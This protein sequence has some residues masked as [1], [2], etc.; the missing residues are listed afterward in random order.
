MSIFD[1]LT[2]PSQYTGSH[3]NRFD[4]SGKGKGIEGRADRPGTDGY[5]E[6]FKR[7]PE[8][9]NLSKKDS[10]VVSRLTNPK[11]FTGT[12]KERFDAEGKGKGIDGRVDRHENSG[13][14]QG[15]AIKDSSVP[16]STPSSATKAKVVSSDSEGD[17]SLKSEA[18]PAKK[19]ATPTKK[20]AAP[21]KSP[22]AAGTTKTLAKSPSNSSTTS[23]GA[24][25]PSIF[26]KLTDPS[27]YT[28]S[29]KNRF[30]SEGKGR[31]LAGR[32][33]ANVSSDGYVSGFKP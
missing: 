13:Y 9:K 23:T 24:K 27:Q 28:G 14:V 10:D 15:S 1:K 32:T 29:H 30:D 8:K 17:L 7:T 25:K 26:D 5:V 18:S 4:A 31:G 2:D 19:S 16:A 11:N 3:K 22:A 6:G 12:H 33:D 21:A 20:S